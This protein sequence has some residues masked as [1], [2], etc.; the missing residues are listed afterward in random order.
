[1]LAFLFSTEDIAIVV[2]EKVLP[3]NIEW[4]FLVLL[5]PGEV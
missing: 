2:V 1:M 4:R 3:E 5:I